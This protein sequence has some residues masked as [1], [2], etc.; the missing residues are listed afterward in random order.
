[1]KKHIT[2]T[3]KLLYIILLCVGVLISCSDDDDDTTNSTSTA[4]VSANPSNGFIVNSTDFRAVI[5]FG[6]QNQFQTTLEPGQM[7]NMNLQRNKTHLVHVVLLN[8]S[9]RALSEFVNNFYID[10]TALDNQL[11]DFL[12]S[13][14]VEFVTMSGFNNRFG[15]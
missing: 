6:Q 1:M 8:E 7:M 11:R 12:C 3:G 2:T 9:D 14:Y 4:L 13:W 5:D 10:N 15:S